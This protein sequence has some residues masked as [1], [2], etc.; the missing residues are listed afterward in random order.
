MWQSCWSIESHLIAFFKLGYT[1]F[2]QYILA[3]CWS[4][5]TRIPSIHDPSNPIYS[6]F[7]KVS[8]TCFEQYILAPLVNQIASF[9]YSWSIES[10]LIPFFQSELYLFRAVYSCRSIGSRVPSYRI[11]LKVS[12]LIWAMLVL[13]FFDALWV[14]PQCAKLIA[15]VMPRAQ[16]WNQSHK[17]SCSLTPYQIGLFAASAFSLFASKSFLSV[18]IQISSR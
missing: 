16:P 7:F 6:H 14:P 9:T 12:C 8:Y 13:Y 4:I 3:C 18:R 5:E 15:A 11:F 17:S 10:H 2:E 1:C